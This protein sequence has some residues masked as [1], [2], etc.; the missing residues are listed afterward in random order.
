MW[1]IVN[2]DTTV[3]V[4]NRLKTV[5]RLLEKRRPQRR[6]PVAAVSTTYAD[7]AY[8]L[9]FNASGINPLNGQNARHHDFSA[10]C[11]LTI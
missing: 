8:Y 7:K 2:R 1:N 4:E 6:V 9:E 3:V 11:L 5:L 10:R